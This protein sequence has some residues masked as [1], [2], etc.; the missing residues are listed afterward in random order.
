MIVRLVRDEPRVKS[1]Q[2]DAFVFRKL[3]DFPRARK[4]RCPCCIWS[5]ASSFL[6]RIERG[7][8]LADRFKHAARDFDA[9]VTES[10]AAVAPAFCPIIFD[11]LDEWFERELD[12]RYTDSVERRNE[13]V[14]RMRAQAP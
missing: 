7:V 12:C 9:S 2:R 10:R 3:C 11:R 5:N 13:V 1:H 14:N 6:D 4:R 8:V